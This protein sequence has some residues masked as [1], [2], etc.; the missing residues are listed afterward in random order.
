MLHIIII[1]MSQCFHPEQVGSATANPKHVCLEKKP[2]KGSNSILIIPVSAV[3]P[4]GMG[5]GICTVVKLL[6]LLIT[7]KVTHSAPAAKEKTRGVNCIIR[8]TT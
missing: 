1:I 7:Y 6:H 8:Q 3:V 2:L 4:I 5:I